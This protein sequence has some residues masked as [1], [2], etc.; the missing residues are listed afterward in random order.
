M[1]FHAAILPNQARGIL[2]AKMAIEPS[3][4]SCT[5]SNDASRISWRPLRVAKVVEG[6]SPVIGLENGARQPRVVPGVPEDRRTEQHAFRGKHGSHVGDRG[7]LARERPWQ[8]MEH[9]AQR[10]GV[11]QPVDGEWLADVGLDRRDVQA[12]QSPGRIVQGVEVGIEEGDGSTVRD[13]GSCQEESQYQDRRRGAGCRGAAGTPPR[14]ES[15]GTATRLARRSRGSV[16]RR[17]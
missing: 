9:A 1:R 11:E 3:V 14:G 4:S 6:A 12:L 13:S 8:A 16:S 2:A 5:C 15:S 17:P 7:S 10:G